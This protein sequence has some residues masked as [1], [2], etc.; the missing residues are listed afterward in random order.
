MLHT[1]TPSD[2]DASSA[3]VL[4]SLLS[5]K[6]IK[7]GMRTAYGMLPLTFD[8]PYSSTM[9][10][11]KYAYKIHPWDPKTGVGVLTTVLINTSCSFKCQYIGQHYS[12]KGSK[13]R[14]H[15]TIVNTTF[16]NICVFVLWLLANACHNPSLRRC[17][18]SK[19]LQWKTLKHQ[20]N[21]KSTLFGVLTDFSSFVCNPKQTKTRKTWF[22]SPGVGNIK[23][24]FSST[25]VCP[26]PTQW[27]F[28]KTTTLNN[29]HYLNTS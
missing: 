13:S 7:K 2:V 1:L 15:S 29:Q 16:P 3:K 11:N 22:C 28:Y 21:V 14:S 27:W 17:T 26:K 19:L 10:S 12:N 9:S 20:V 4:T 18:P 5:Y 24:L 8:T 6:A 25:V 23:N